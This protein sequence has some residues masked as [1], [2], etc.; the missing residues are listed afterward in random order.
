MKSDEFK[1]FLI[2]LIYVLTG[3]IF[4]IEYNDLI[5]FDT[6]RVCGSYLFFIGLI[7]KFVK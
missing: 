3:V 1:K 4:L 2:I 5:V 6:T 7:C